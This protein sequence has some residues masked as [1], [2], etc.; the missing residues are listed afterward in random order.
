MSNDREADTNSFVSFVYS[1]CN[2]NENEQLDQVKKVF[3]SIHKAYCDKEVVAYEVYESRERTIQIFHEMLEQNKI[4]KC[5]NLFYSKENANDCNEIG[6]YRYIGETR[7][8]DEISL[9]V[10]DDFFDY[11]LHSSRVKVTQ[12]GLCVSQYKLYGIEKV[13]FINEVLLK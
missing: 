3:K 9:M 10:K 12:P 6:L 13:P 11:I 4:N 1:R 2:N 8:R 7:T 5:I